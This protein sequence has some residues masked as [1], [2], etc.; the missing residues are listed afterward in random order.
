MIIDYKTT[1]SNYINSTPNSSLSK[2]DFYKMRIQYFI[3][4]KFEFVFV[5]GNSEFFY[6][7]NA[8][9]FY[10]NNYTIIDMNEMKKNQNM[11][12]DELINAQKNYKVN[13]RKRKLNKLIK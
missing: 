6:K 4:E 3:Q 12:Y 9:Y 7:K 11:M 1:Y 13:S 10:I 5:Y 8:F 2:S